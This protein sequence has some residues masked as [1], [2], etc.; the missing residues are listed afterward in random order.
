MYS[1]MTDGYRIA[2]TDGDDD[3]VRVI[4][5][6]LSAQP[7]SD[8]EWET[9]N[10]S[11][12]AVRD[13]FPLMRCDPLRP[14]RPGAKPFIEEI[15]IAYD[16]TLIQWVEVIRESG[17]LWEVFKPTGDCWPALL[18]PQEE[19]YPPRSAPIMCWPYARTTSASIIPPAHGRG[20]RVPRCDHPE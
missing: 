20:R 14:P 13:S 9:G 3:P 12:Q 16:G 6:E 2:L 18:A 7:I 5:R 11:Y 19:A 1:A 10:S 8:E 17:N 4:E 15:D